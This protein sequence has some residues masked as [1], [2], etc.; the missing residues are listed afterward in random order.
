MLSCACYAAP[1]LCHAAEP[2]SRVP[3]RTHRTLVDLPGYGPAA[4]RTAAMRDRWARVTRQYMRGRTQLAC[5]F[6][7][8]DAS[9]GVTKDDEAFLDMLDQAAATREAGPLRPLR[10]HVVLTKAD[11][12]S[13]RDLALSYEVRPRA[14]GLTLPL[15]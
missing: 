11:L 10:C 14:A 13:P 15:A 8:I 9:L 4:G 6:M 12:L 7:L 5:A 3:L 1:S 2:L